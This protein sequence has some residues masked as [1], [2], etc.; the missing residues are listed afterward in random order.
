MSLGI[1]LWLSK[2]VTM[3]TTWYSRT[4]SIPRVILNVNCLSKIISLG[5]F[6]RVTNTTK[7]VSVKLNLLNHTKSDS[8]FNYGMRVLV[9]S[10]EINKSTGIGWHRDG[11]DIAYFQNNFKKVTL[12]FFVIC[13]CIIGYYWQEQILLYLEFHL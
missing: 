9:Y 4:T 7:D 5:F 3:N 12:F 6:F 11:K 10:D 13:L 1:W 2:S 8:L